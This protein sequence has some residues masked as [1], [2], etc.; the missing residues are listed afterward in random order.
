[1]SFSESIIVVGP[2]CPVRLVQELLNDLVVP[3][4]TFLFLS[5]DTLSDSDALIGR[6]LS[7]ERV[8]LIPSSARSFFSTRHLKGIQEHLR[9][10]EDILV[11]IPQS[12]YKHPGSAIASLLIMLLSG[13]TITILR[14]LEDISSNS[15][16]TTSNLV[17]R[18]A[19]EKWLLINLNLEILIK[20]LGEKGWSL[21]PG[22]LKDFLK[23]ALRGLCYNL[24]FYDIGDGEAPPVNFQPL[25]STPEALRKDVEKAITVAS[26]WIR[27]L[28]GSERF[29]KNK[30]VLEIG[31]GTNFGAVLI[32]ACL[33]A[34]V[35]VTDR[36]LTPW[37]PVYHPKYYAL[38]RDFVAEHWTGID[39]S[40][41]DKIISKGRYCR[42]SIS[43]Y[44]LP[45]E[46]LSA[47]PEQSMDLIVS[48]AVLEHLYD[49]R[50]A[51]SQLGRLT[52]SGGLGIH[53]V[54][55]RDHRDFS[56]PLEYLILSNKEFY[57]LFR[58]R[59]GE[60]G[61]RLR[62]GEMKRFFETS[63]FEVLQFQ[64]EMFVEKGYLKEIRRRL[65]Q[66]RSSP[67]RNCDDTELYCIFGTFL[68][69]KLHTGKRE[70]FWRW[71]PQKPSL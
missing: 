47:L 29:L 8:S 57:H 67:Y 22:F 9:S 3:G 20:E 63:G 65:C 26:L 56:C 61:N 36:F 24:G 12:P 33:G 41:L 34:E 10:S 43:L 55:F 23:H 70:N 4:K 2:G 64:P 18:N 52:K 17:I 60:C 7:S 27:L 5:P 51:L 6:A 28:P 25:D 62:P 39:L 40:P 54:D 58:D 11:L 32:L 69:R 30:R 45:V 53:V 14:H 1:M 16:D 19:S 66:C 50:L 59:H 42:E 13:R 71:L 38:L 21:C 46:K 49:T 48:H 44:N 35:S 31:P 15:P 68:V 37:D